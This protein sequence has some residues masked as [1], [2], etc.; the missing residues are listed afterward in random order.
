M[1]GRIV[2]LEAALKNLTVASVNPCILAFGIVGVHAADPG[3][4]QPSVALNLGNHCAKGIE[5]S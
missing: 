4:A 1:D 3:E 2:H 5:M